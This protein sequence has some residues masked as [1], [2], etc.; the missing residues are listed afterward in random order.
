MYM[1][2][3]RPFAMMITPP[4]RRK[5]LHLSHSFAAPQAHGQHAGPAPPPHCCPPHCV[6][7]QMPTSPSPLSP[8]ALSCPCRTSTHETSQHSAMKRQQ[9]TYT[10]THVVDIPRRPLRRLYHAVEPAIH[11]RLTTQLP[12]VNCQLPVVSKRG[13]SPS[14]LGRYLF[15][16]NVRKTAGIRPVRF[17]PPTR[18]TPVI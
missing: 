16:A 7:D 13:L 12:I 18:F 14:T 2:P 9:P 8:K 10:Q 6:S 5:D 4:P 1:N 11:T 3:P 17:G 15:V